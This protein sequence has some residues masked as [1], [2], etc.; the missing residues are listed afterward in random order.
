LSYSYLYKTKTLYFWYSNE[1]VSY[2]ILLEF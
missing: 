2:S 1:P